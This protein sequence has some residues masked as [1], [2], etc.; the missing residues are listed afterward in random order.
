MFHESADIY[1]A[2]YLSQGKDYAAE[3]LKIRE[4]AGRCQRSAGRSLLDVACGTG[5]HAANLREYF[6]VEGLDLDEGMVAAARRKYP[7]LKFSQGDML[8]FRLN[9]TFDVVTCLFSS[10]GYLKTPAR[11]DQ[12]IQTM[13]NHLTP[14]GV[15]IVEP[16]FTPETWHPG[17][18]HAVYVNQP[19]LKIAR[20]NISEGD[21]RLSWFEFHYLVATREGVRYFTE[22]HELGL[23][24]HEE[25]LAAFQ[26]AGLEVFHDPDGLYG[27]GLYIGVSPNS[28]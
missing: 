9:R 6:D 5:L 3:A 4:L 16:W 21:G 26:R 8:D 15:L 25:Y 18:A 22:R 7:N 24:T 28:A 27:R 11:L 19:D 17:T 14:G 10:I 13:G 1:D 20:M 12:A 2:I 23:F